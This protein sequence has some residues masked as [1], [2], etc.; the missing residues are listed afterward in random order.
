MSGHFTIIIPFDYSYSRRFQLRFPLQNFT[1][2][3]LGADHPRL[4]PFTLQVVLDQLA[5][6]RE[7]TPP[8]HHNWYWERTRSSCR[9]MSCCTPRPRVVN[10]SYQWPDGLVH[11]HSLFNCGSS[12][13]A[14]PTPTRIPSCM[15]LI[16]PSTALVVI[17]PAPVGYFPNHVVL[18][19]NASLP[20]SPD[21]SVSIVS[22]PLPLSLRPEIVRM[23]M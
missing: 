16:L 6:N 19:T 1:I 22:P 13:T 20:C 3:R 4:L 12:F 8:I 9:Q 10:V 7:P 5:V 15:V 11:F 21:R 23:S 17:K 14:V 18:L 2:I